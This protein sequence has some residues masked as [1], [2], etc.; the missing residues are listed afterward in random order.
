MAHRRGR[1]KNPFKLKL[2]R[3]IVHSIVSVIFATL[4]LITLLSFTRQGP[5]L[6]NVYLVMYRAFGWTM[7]VVPFLFLAISLMMMSL[8]WALASP[9][10]LLGGVMVFTGLLGLAQAGT[11]G[12]TIY[13]AIAVFLTRV[14]AV[15]VYLAVT[16]TGIMVLTNTPLE[17]FVLGI[18]NS[19]TTVK[20]ALAKREKTKSTTVTAKPFSDEVMKT[21]I[22]IPGMNPVVK[23][24]VEPASPQTLLKREVTPDFEAQIG[25]VNKDGVNKIWK[26]PP[27]SI[28]S[29]DKGG[30]ADRGDIKENAAIIEST[31]ES[32]GIRAKVAEVNGGPAITQYAI[33][34]A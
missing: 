10:L 3:E 5:L 8:K 7:L 6:T 20:E 27:L 32:F 12:V 19:L 14:G 11:L 23:E 18:V 2:R 30:K 1:R 31:L 16:F 28:L 13:E 29:A 34:I 24:K 21:K 4:A 15:I 22:N 9:S 25:G 26:S 33:K 17:D